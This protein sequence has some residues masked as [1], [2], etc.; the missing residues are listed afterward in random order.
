MSATA[1]QFNSAPERSLDQRMDALAR[2]N[3]VRS[4][5]AALKTALK[6]GDVNLRDVLDDPPSY[7]LTAKVL[8]LLTAA[9]KRG[10]KKA[11]RIMERCRISPSKTVGGLSERQRAELLAQLDG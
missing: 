8:D 4:Q 3:E 11:A 5:R 6:H 1:R 9:P 10:P 7:L 2:A